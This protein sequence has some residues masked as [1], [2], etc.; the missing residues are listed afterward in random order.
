MSIEVKPVDDPQATEV[1]QRA[2]LAAVHLPQFSDADFKSS[3]AEL[4]EL[5]RT[6]GVDVV[7]ELLQVRRQTDPKYL[8][9]MVRLAPQI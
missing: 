1:R 2:I 4:K 9:V 7:D 5:A 8:H 6:A 3:L